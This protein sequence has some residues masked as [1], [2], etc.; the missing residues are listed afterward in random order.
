MGVSL[1]MPHKLLS[2]CFILTI[3]ATSST[4]NDNHK[5][6]KIEYFRRV[7]TPYPKVTKVQQDGGVT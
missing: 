2:S 3:I 6:S 7:S 1:L 4:I 5:F